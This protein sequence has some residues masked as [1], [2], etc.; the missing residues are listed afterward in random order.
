MV[1]KIEV[2]ANA[3]LLRNRK[4]EGTAV[5][6]ILRDVTERRRIEKSL[7]E[8]E[9]RYHGILMGYTMLFLWRVWMAKYSNCNE[10]ALYMYG[11]TREQM[12]SKIV[13]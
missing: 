9:R 1:G 13:P 2:E 3:N 6:T 12:L 7:Q 5:V 8:S 10:S 4:G 11:Y